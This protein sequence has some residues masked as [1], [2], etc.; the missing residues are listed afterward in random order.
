[1][2][3]CIDVSEH[4]GSINW[5]TVKDSGVDYARIRCGFGQDIESQDDKRYLE[6]IQEALNAG[7]K[8]QF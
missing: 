4:N 1:M 2:G 5:Y 7:V 3:N 8:V 6:N